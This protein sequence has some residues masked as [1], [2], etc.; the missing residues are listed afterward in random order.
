MIAAS[1]LLLAGAAGAAALPRLAQAEDE[2]A[3]D[4]EF[5]EYL[6]TLEGDQEDWTWFADESKDDKRI[7]EDESAD[8]D[9]EQ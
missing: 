6:D 1:R 9:T 3:L 8:E 7:A 2:A 5:L 4:A